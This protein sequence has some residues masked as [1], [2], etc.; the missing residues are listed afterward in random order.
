[1][2]SPSQVDLTEALS[3][4]PRRSGS[5]P[6][7]ATGST[8]SPVAPPIAPSSVSALAAPPT[9]PPLPPL[10]IPP[11]GTE[12]MTPPPPP[13]SPPAR[14]PRPPR[15]PPPERPSPRPAAPSAMCE[16]LVSPLLVEKYDA[17]VVLL[18]NRPSRRN[19]LDRPLLLALA[20]ELAQAAADREVRAIVLTG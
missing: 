7:A 16:T 1:P 18:L 15:P 5:L 17:V 11:P 9:V 14:P 3:M 20:H 8:S 6:P 13:P 10:G 12:N 19:A 2:P 4:P